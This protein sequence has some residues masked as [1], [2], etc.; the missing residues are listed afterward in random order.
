MLIEKMTLKLEIRKLIKSHFQSGKTPRE[1]YKMLNKTVPIWTIYR[2]IKRLSNG[3]IKADI[4]TGRP[5]TIRTKTFIA[6]INR[7]STQ[8][9]KRK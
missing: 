9:T 6:K 2:W 3:V 4:S 8:N 7:N 5:R 1:I